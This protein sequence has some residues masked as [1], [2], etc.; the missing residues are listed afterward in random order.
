MTELLHVALRAIGVVLPGAGVLGSVELRGGAP[1]GD[2]G[3]FLGAM[4]LSLL[5][6]AVWAA[7]DA[8][9]ASPGR[10]LLR[11]VATAVVVGF[12]LGLATT[13]MEP[14]SPAGPERTAEAVWLSLFYG[15]PLLVSAGLGVAGG[16]AHRQ[17]RRRHEDTAGTGT[18]R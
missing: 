2:F 17:S 10:V 12:G 11:W 4:G 6:A 7:F 1:D 9:R 15:V 16:A 13:L 18:G 14:G 5:T 3:T 8:R